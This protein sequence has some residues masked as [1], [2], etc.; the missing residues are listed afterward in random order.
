MPF[1]DG[2]ARAPAQEIA[3]SEG[4]AISLASDCYPRVVSS[5]RRKTSFEVD[6]AK[7][8]KAKSVL[9][10]TTLTETVDQALDEVIGL[11]RRRELVDLLFSDARIELD[12]REVMSGAWR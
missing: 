9:G 2:S 5:N 12:N 11:Q 8:E 1:V 4:S 3:D 7:V 10:T 6:F